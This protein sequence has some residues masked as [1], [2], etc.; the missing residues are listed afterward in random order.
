MK[1]EGDW[2]R[3]QWQNLGSDRLCRRSLDSQLRTPAIAALQ[4]LG[5]FGKLRACRIEHRFGIIGQPM[6]F[7]FG[8][9]VDE[10]G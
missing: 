6:P 10:R 8:Y 7:V 3:R 1:A 2:E 9:S 4:L 5:K